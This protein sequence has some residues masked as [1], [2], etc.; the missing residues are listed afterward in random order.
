MNNEL[1]IQT[2]V[3][4]D[5]YASMRM[6]SPED[7]IN[8]KNVSKSENYL[9][10]TSDKTEEVEVSVELELENGNLSFFARMNNIEPD[11]IISGGEFTC[12]IHLFG[13]SLKKEYV[14]EGQTIFFIGNRRIAKG[15][16][17]EVSNVVEKPIITNT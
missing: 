1:N 5:F 3:Q 13:T 7:A 6:Y 14:T 4:I 9:Q 8:E 15:Q 12:N 11:L 10:S 2:F 17:L 16:I